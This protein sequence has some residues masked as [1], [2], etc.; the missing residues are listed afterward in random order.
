M[1]LGI[2]LA[3]TCDYGLPGLWTGLLFALITTAAVATVLS[4][5]TPDWDKE[6]ARTIKRLKEDNKA[7]ID[8]ERIE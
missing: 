4:V 6:V 2:W 1:P 5:W 8:V 3:F 7:P